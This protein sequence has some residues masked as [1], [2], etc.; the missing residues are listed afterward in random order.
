MFSHLLPRT[1]LQ[2]LC[3]KSP[4]PPKLIIILK[5]D[6]VFFSSPSPL[7]SIQNQFRDAIFTLARIFPGSCCGGSPF[8]FFWDLAP[9][10]L[11]GM[12]GF[13][14]F[15]V[16]GCKPPL[17]LFCFI[18]ELSI[19]SEQDERWKIITLEHGSHLPMRTVR[20]YCRKSENLWVNL[21][22]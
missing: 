15:V 9:V 8:D 20:L 18:W 11:V 19:R 10:V 13:E 3:N 12:K 14:E 5:Y 7:Q 17:W 16:F 6:I 2:L 4:I 1:S 21:S 22:L